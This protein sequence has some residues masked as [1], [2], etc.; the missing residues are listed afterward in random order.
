[1]KLYLLLCAKAA[2]SATSVT[3]P[4]APDARSDRTAR[5][6]V[7][8]RASN[9][10]ADA[11]GKRGP[12]SVSP[13]STAGRLDTWD[14]DAERSNLCPSNPDCD[15]VALRRGQ[16][17]PVCKARGLNSCAKMSDKANWNTVWCKDYDSEETTI[18]ELQQMLDDLKSMI[19]SCPK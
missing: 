7:K 6:E 11:R 19:L 17:E 16:T 1:M 4:R 12:T 15:C 9:P 8:P 3:P 10:V 5:D 13:I 18:A 2:A 14:R